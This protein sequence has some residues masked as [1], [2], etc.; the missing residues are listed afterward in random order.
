MWPN[1]RTVPRAAAKSKMCKI[2]IIALDMEASRRLTKWL[3]EWKEKMFV[4]C[5]IPAKFLNYDTPS[6]IA[7]RECQST[8]DAGQKIATDMARAADK[9]KKGYR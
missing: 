7:I 3:E 2:N 4:S 5:G 6:A 1:S 9:A 8:I